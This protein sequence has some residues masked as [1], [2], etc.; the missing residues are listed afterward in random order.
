MTP[1]LGDAGIA[2]AIRKIRAVAIAAQEG[3]VWL[4]PR[5]ERQGVF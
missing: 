5:S 1:E 2:T 4:R 3:A